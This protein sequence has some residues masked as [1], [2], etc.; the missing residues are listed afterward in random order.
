MSDLNLFDGTV[1]VIILLSAFF[2]YSRGAIR[3][4]MSLV[5]WIIAAIAAYFFAPQAIPLVVE[6]PVIGEFLADSCE[7][8]IIVSFTLVF[9]LFLILC[10]IATL[11]L[12]SMA[13]K[14]IL[15]P[16]NKGMGL[17]FGVFRGI[18]IVALVLVL[19]EAIFSGSQMFTTITESKSASIFHSLQL[20]IQEQIPTDGIN[21]F[22]FLYE[23]VTA[24]CASGPASIN[25]LTPPSAPIDTPVDNAPSEN[26]I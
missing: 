20:G 6:L 23:N 3:E 4:I 12:S 9:A 24:N 15:G 5:G 21:R 10:G 11:I 17:I 14:S 22:T 26:Q 1:I 8:A 18:L 19:Y 2:A 25:D 16:F 7:L 13:S